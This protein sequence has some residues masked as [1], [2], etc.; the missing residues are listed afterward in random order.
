MPSIPPSR[1]FGNSWGQADFRRLNLSAENSD[2]HS[3]KSCP[4]RPRDL[5]FR[6]NNF[7][8][9]TNAGD[10]KTRIRSR[11]DMRLALLK[12]LTAAKLEFIE[13][14]ESSKSRLLFNRRSMTTV[15]LRPVLTGECEVYCR[16]RGTLIKRAPDNRALTLSF[17]VQ[18]LLVMS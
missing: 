15:E 9:P 14:E 6:R 16:S 5:T 2:S 10:G 7:P 8:K 11:E 12:C 1:L 4:P 13:E 18:E 17:G 3:A